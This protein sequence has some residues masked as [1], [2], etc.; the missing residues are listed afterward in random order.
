M[1]QVSILIKPASALCNLRCQYCFYADI[2]SQREV[3]SFGR[4]KKV[5]MK[6]LI[7]Q[8]YVDLNDGDQLTIAFQGGEPTLAGLPYF[9]EFVAQVHSQKKAVNVQYALQTNGMRIDNEWCLFLKENNFLVGLSIDGNE[10]YHDLFR[11]D[12]KGQGTYQ[13]VLESK[14]LFD[15]YHI[16]YNILC[17]L[18]NQLAKEPKKVYQFL[19]KENIKFIQF[20][21]CLSELQATK[22]DIYSLTPERFANFYHT[23]LQLWLEELSLGTYRSIKLFDDMFNLLVNRQ[24]NACG[25]TGNCTIQYVIEADGSVYPC[26][27]YVLDEYR[28]GNIQEQT[29]RELFEQEISF[30]FLCEKKVMKTFCQ[31]C[32]YKNLCCGGCKRMNEVM[33]VN[34]NEDFCGFKQVLADFINKL[35]VVEQ[36]FREIE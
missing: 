7:D 19:Q 33:Y 21:P 9:K 5:V 18:T 10:E 31:N 15:Q 34:K 14:K 36:V 17:V 12:R 24:V 25:L 6:K 28:L 1:K 22:R 3:R 30:K 20:I 29:L 8:V 27:F 2:S 11:V 32:P 13:K 35:P 16:D 4:M 26:D 23:M